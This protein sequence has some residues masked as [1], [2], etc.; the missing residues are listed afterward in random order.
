MLAQCALGTIDLSL[1]TIF[2]YC[3]QMRECRNLLPMSFIDTI[4]CSIIYTISSIATAS[5]ILN[6]M[7]I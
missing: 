4:D 5:Q 2:V 1:L 6:M 3:N 7:D